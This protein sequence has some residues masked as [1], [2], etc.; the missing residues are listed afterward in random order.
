MLTV[1]AQRILSPTDMETRTLPLKTHRLLK[2]TTQVPRNF[3]FLNKTI[4]IF[5]TCLCSHP[6]CFII[7]L[8]YPLSTRDSLVEDRSQAELPSRR[9][10]DIMA[11]KSLVSWEGK[12]ES[13]NIEVIFVFQQSGNID[14]WRPLYSVFKKFQNDLMIR[15]EISLPGCRVWW[16]QEPLMS[17]C[18]WERLMDEDMGDYL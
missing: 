7:Y 4:C 18:R 8:L 6:H 16:G 1:S 11:L 15:L 2:G 9:N 5:S 12:G 3:F 10:H 14:S 13:L 17:F